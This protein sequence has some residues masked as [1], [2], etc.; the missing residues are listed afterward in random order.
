LIIDKPE[1][2]C[3]LL[4]ISECIAPTTSDHL[5]KQCQ[6]VGRMIARFIATLD[7]SG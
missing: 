2:F 3:C 5:I 7:A 1:F 4:A 6:V